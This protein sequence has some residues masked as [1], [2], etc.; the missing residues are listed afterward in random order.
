MAK[1][2]KQIDDSNTW[3]EKIKKLV[4][5]A[6][7][8]DDMLMSKLVLKGGNALD[9]VHRTCAR[10]S[11][12]IDLSMDG[13]FSDDERAKLNSRIEQA[14][15]KSFQLVG[16]RVFDFKLLNQPPAVSEELA[17]FW[18]GYYI[19]FKLI[20]DSFHQAYNNDIKALRNRSLELGNGK[21]FFIDISKH[22]YVSGKITE[23]LDGY[24]IYAYTPEMIVAEK[25]RAICQQMKEYGPVVNR[26]RSGSARAK[27]F[28]D[29]Q[30]IVNEKGIDFSRLQNK[31][32]LQKVFAQKRVPTQFL[33]MIDKYREFHRTSFDAV[34]ATVKPGIRLNDFDF[35][36]DFVIDMIKRL[37]PLG[38]E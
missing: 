8:S 38:N 32:L 13:D 9:L 15:Q 10:A 29:I 18:G 24:T 5:I 3:I 34:R 35:Y 36:F 27:D 20:L 7:F 4:V 28:V 2:V 11:V 6:M 16:Y 22:E 21:K 33:G 17:D 23:D 19:E 26:S 37:E 14:L 25:L 30:V 1:K 31:V 12:D